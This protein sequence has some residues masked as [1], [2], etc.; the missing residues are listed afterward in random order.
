MRTPVQEK[1]QQL[2]S[3]SRGKNMA[4]KK[5]LDKTLKKTTENWVNGIQN[6]S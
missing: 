4:T 5:K 2:K 3:N 6:T 1:R